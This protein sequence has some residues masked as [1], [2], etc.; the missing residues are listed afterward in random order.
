MKGRPIL[1][2]VIGYII[3]II[4]GLYFKIN[5][6]LFH[7]LIITIYF[8]YKKFFQSNFQ[9]NEFKLISIKR[10]S[11]YLKLI[12]EPS[13]IFIFIIFSIISNYIILG[14]EEKYQN[15]Y[16]SEGDAHFFAIVESEKEEKEYKDRYK[17]KVIKFQQNS[18]FENQEMYIY[19]KKDGYKLQ[20][21]D[22]IEIIGT[23]NQI[24][25]RRNYG[26]F[27]YQN[28]LK[29][30]K[31]SGIV[32]VSNLKILEHNQENYAKTTLHYIGVQIK[33]N[34]DKSFEK[35]TDSLLKGLLLGDTSKIEEDIKEDFRV[36]NMSHIL[37]ISGMH[38]NYIVLALGL[39]FSKSLGKRKAR[40]ITIIFLI[41]YLF[42]TGA[43][44]SVVRA[45]LMSIVGIGATFFHRKN[46]IATSIA[47]SLLI[48]LLYN[49]YLIC[50]V[51]LQLSYLGTI[52][53]IIFH[54]FVLHILDKMTAKW[55]KYKKLKLLDTIKEMLAVTISAQIAL[56]PIILYHFNL[57]SCYFLIS[58]FF[59]SI[60]I[61]PIIMMGF[62]F[63]VLYFIS[64]PIATILA[65]FVQI[66]V[67]I[68]INISKLG[69]LPFS[70]IY[71]PT[72]SVITICLYYVGILII[73]SVYFIYQAKD[74]S[75]TQK[76][77]QNLISLLRYKMRLKKKK[78]VAILVIFLS[79][80]LIL[81][82]YPKKLEI[83]FVDVGQGDC[84]FMVTPYRKTILVDGGGS[85]LSNFDV[86][87]NTL[88]PYLLDRG[89]TKID[90][91]FI[92]HF[93]S[94]H[95]RSA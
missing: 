7:F 58:N 56:I 77:I 42:L 81:Q 54:P 47:I 60:I 23:Y 30:K 53:I 40:A 39:I 11:R 69:N 86:G 76:K 78:C 31:I 93:D 90:Y 19:T 70:K 49:P 91:L 22:K 66:G 15:F 63:I 12:I 4:W 57:F 1:V 79:I 45:V 44:P 36:A 51:G 5:I 27:D 33:N 17:I 46:D 82:V 26:G 68:L 92:S 21:G 13:V 62:L 25:A 3:G 14:E 10:Y 52:G 9:K 48:L 2:A 73:K 35:E 61:G 18:K 28:Y 65:V 55:Q 24:S 29:I 94:D 89:Y 71:I 43:S 64:V 80:I 87:K 75:N 16:Q 41:I 88:L 67:Q 74:L 32:T 8:I 37:A 72:P 34:I 95:V 83:H 38:V 6:I 20:Y 50:H 59:I 85:E 84:T